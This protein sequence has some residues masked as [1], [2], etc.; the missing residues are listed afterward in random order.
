MEKRWMRFLEKCRK[1]LAGET[2]TK[3]D[4]FFMNGTGCGELQCK[5]KCGIL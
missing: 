1:A 2:P 4:P 3:I 5:R